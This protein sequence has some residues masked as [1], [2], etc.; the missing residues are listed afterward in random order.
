MVETVAG[1]KLTRYKIGLQLAHVQQRTL[2]GTMVLKICTELDL[3]E[4]YE[5]SV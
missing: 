5:R 4:W 1:V 3:K 2:F